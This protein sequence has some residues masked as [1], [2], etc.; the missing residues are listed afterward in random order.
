MGRSVSV[1]YSREKGRY[2]SFTGTIL[3]HTVPGI[4]INNDPNSAVFKNNLP[5]GFLRCDGSVKNVKEYYALAQVLGI[6]DDSRFKKETTALRNANLEI[7]DLGSFQLPDLGSKVI[8]ASRAS[9]E[10]QNTTRES[11]PNI[12]R[13]GVETSASSNVGDTITMNYTSN[14]AGGPRFLIEPQ[15]GINMSGSVKFNLPTKT[16]PTSLVIEDFQAHSHNTTSG[17]YHGLTILNHTGSHESGSGHGK[18][19]NGFGANDS[20]GNIID[21]TQTNILSGEATHTH[22][23]IKPVAYTPTPFSYSFDEF[24]ASMEEVSSRISVDVEN[25]KVLNQVVT[26]FVLVEYIIKF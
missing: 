21:E 14:D 23:I 18:G 10:Y 11:A 1:N 8:V 2:G 7:N 19:T 12:N 17:I 24:S 6:G 3:I 15:S 25:I 26:P 9:G 5:A 20:G 4:G 16:E 22:R 13:V